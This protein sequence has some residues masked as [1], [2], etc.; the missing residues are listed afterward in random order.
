MNKNHLTKASTQN[1]EFHQMMKTKTS[2]IFLNKK[3][4]RN[5]QVEITEGLN[6]HLVQVMTI[7]RRQLTI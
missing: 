6:A 5:F 3:Y 2:K 7:N 1:D 4:Q